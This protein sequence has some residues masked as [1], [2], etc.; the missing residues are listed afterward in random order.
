MIK[1]KIKFIY[2]F[3]KRF[4]IKSKLMYLAIIEKIYPPKYENYRIPP[5][6]YR[7]LTTATLVTVNE[8]INYG[9][10]ASSMIVSVLENEGINL[11]STHKMLEFGCGCGR[12]LR[13]VKVK[14]PNIELF[15]TDVDSELIYWNKKHLPDVAKWNINDY[16]PP[17]KYES[18]RFNIVFLI[19][20]FT[21][22]DQ[23]SQNRWLIEFERILKPGGLL[24]ITVIPLSSDY[25]NKKWD[26]VDPDGMVYR[27]RRNEVVSRSWIKKKT[28]HPYYID[29][30]HSA[31]YCKKKWNDI[32]K[33]NGIYSGAIRGKQSL[34]VLQK[35]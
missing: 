19:S 23:E 14:Y 29:A 17:I 27:Y 15:G 35:T 16:N 11:N 5:P 1:D 10:Q 28:I 20:V 24:L 25:L 26:F 33:V 13:H 3:Y 32:F 8:H 6:K 4:Y 18:D 31:E 7:Q 2:R 21:H 12:I 30:Q 9:K 34:V 22:M